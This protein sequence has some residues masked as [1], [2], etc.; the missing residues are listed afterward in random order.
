MNPFDQ[1]D[2]PP[3]AA[4][5]NPFDTFDAPKANPFDAFDAPQAITDPAAHAVQNLHDPQAREA[6]WK[7]FQQQA[8]QPVTAGSVASATGSFLKGA[9]PL[10]DD[11]GNWHWPLGSA[12]YGFGKGIASTVGQEAGTALEGAKQIGQAAGAMGLGGSF[13]DSIANVPD[14]PEGER[15][16]RQLGAGVESGALGA[17]RQI[18]T[19]GRNISAGANALTGGLIG[20]Q[21]KD[22]SDADLRKRFEEAVAYHYAQEQLT[23]GKYLHEIAGQPS[24]WN[25][26]TPTTEELAATGHPVNPE[27]VSEVA[28]TTSP[29]NMLEIGGITNP[30]ANKIIAPAVRGVGAGVEA[31]AGAT[32]KKAGQLLTSKIAKLGTPVGLAA[33]V[34]LTG[35]IHTGAIAGALGTL[36]ATWAGSK[37]AQG[38]GGIVRDAGTEMAGG[39]PT[40]GGFFAN[41]L[42][43]GIVGA[44]GSIPVAGAFALTGENAEDAGNQFWS[45]LG[46]GG[47]M[48]A[49]HGIAASPT[50][51][52]AAGFNSMADHG[53]RVNY[54]DAADTASQAITS[55]L[56]PEAASMVNYWRGHFDGATTPDGKPIRVEAV[57]GDTMRKRTGQ[58]ARGVFF[59]NGT[60][61]VKVGENEG[62]K[63]VPSDPARIAQ[64]FAHEGKHALDDALRASQPKLYHGVF[65]ALKQRFTQNGDG[66]TATP[67]FLNWIQGQMQLH[68]DNL[69]SNG[70]TDD[71][72][73]NALGK[74]DM[75]YWLN[76]ASADIGQG[77]ITGAPLGTFLLDR[78]MTGA[79][80]D[81]VKDIA[82]RAGIRTPQAGALDVPAAQRAMKLIRRQLY[83]QGSEAQQRMQVQ[84][85]PD[86]LA[87][88]MRELAPIAGTQITPTTTT[89]ERAQIRAA[90]RELAEI[91]KDLNQ[92]PAVP[93]PAAG[94]APTPPSRPN[95]PL[96]APAGGTTNAF[97][98][99]NR[100]TDVARILSGKS[101]G[102]PID[103]AKQW[104]A[105]ANGNTVDQMVADAIKQRGA[106]KFPSETPKAEPTK[107]EEPKDYTI[108]PDL[109]SPGFFH[110][111]GPD[112]NRVDDQSRTRAGA[113]QSARK[114]T[115]GNAGGFRIKPN[116]N[117]EAPDVIDAIIEQGGIHLGKLSP[118][119]RQTFIRNQF[120]RT[121]LGTENANLTPDEVARLVQSSGHGDGTISGL[122][123][124]IADAYRVRQEGKTPQGVEDAQEENYRKNNPAPNEEPTPP[125]PNPSEPIHS[126][127]NAVL[128][129]E[130]P[131]D[132]ASRPV[133]IPP[134]PGVGDFERI[135]A[136][137]HAEFLA[138]KAPAK[139]GKNKGQHT[140][141]NQKA[142][143]KAAFQAA[144]A[145][146][147]ETVPLNYEGL[148]QRT[149]AFDE[150]TIT[151]KIDPARAFDSWVIS[152]AKKSG[153][154]TDES[155]KI[156][157]ALQDAIGTTIS[158]D[159]GHAKVGPQAKGE[160][161]TA[162][163]RAASQ[164][165]NSVAKRLSGE[166]EQDT[167]RKTSMPVR[168]AFNSGND[169]FTV[170]GVSQEKLLNNFNHLTERMADLQMPM[171]FRDI[172]DPRFVAAVKAVIANHEHGW[173]GDGSAPAVGT[174]E[175]P[176]IPDPAWK[177]A[178]ERTV[179][180]KEQ[181]D[182]VNALL[183]DES[184][185]AGDSPK[186]KAKARLANA[187][188][189]DYTP[190]GEANE[191]RYRINAAT[192]PVNG[193][194]WSK[195]TLEDPL[196][197]T[198]SPALTTNIGEASQSDESIRQHGKVGDLGR[199]FPKGKTPDRAKTAAAFMPEAAGAENASEKVKERAAK[200][201]KEQG[202][203]SPFFKKWFGESKVVDGTGNPALVHHRTGA[204]DF[205]EFR[206][207]ANFG[208]K[209]QS[210]NVDLTG[211]ENGASRTYDAYLKLENPMRVRDE[212]MAPSN[213][214]QQA[215]EDGV[216]SQKEI[217]GYPY[218]EGD[219]LERRYVIDVLGKH[220]FDGIVYSNE[221]E[222]N[223]DSYIAF[224]PDQIKSATDN[225]G[226]FDPNSPD[227][228]F[229]PDDSRPTPEEETPEDT[230]AP[231]GSPQDRLRSGETS[232]QPL[233]TQEKAK[234]R[235]AA[236]DTGEIPVERFGIKPPILDRAERTKLM[237]QV[238]QATHARDFVTE[239][240][241]ID[242]LTALQAEVTAS[243]IK[244][245]QKDDIDLTK[246]DEDSNIT[247]VERDGRRYIAD[248]HNRV[249]TALDRGD[250]EALADVI[251]FMPE[252]DKPHTESTRSED[253]ASEAESAGIVLKIEDLKGLIARDP[254]VMDNVRAKIKARTGREAQFMPEYYAI[255][256]RPNDEGP[257]AF[258]LLEND[259]APREIYQHP[260]WYTGQPN[261]LAHRQTVAALE[262]IKGKPDAEVTV[263][264][265]A[266]KNSL[267]DGDWVS[268][269]RVYAKQ[270]G[271]ADD[272]SSDV[273]VHAHKVKAKDLRWPGDELGEFGYFPSRADTKFMPEAQQN[274]KQAAQ[275]RQ[276]QRQ[277]PSGRIPSA[278]QR[279]DDRKTQEAARRRIRTT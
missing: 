56:S 169:S 134:S 69:R 29:M 211:R 278:G 13:T 250:T 244:R 222:G 231:S 100:R 142:A 276:D 255:E 198:I 275:Q 38:L 141:E 199:F 204:E 190:E 223:G 3:T 257:R 179:L 57:D 33:D 177:D 85:A 209:E 76:E 158:Y 150:K 140:K 20:T 271:M 103:E 84:T 170:Y 139:A 185:K 14:S 233:T 101:I 17:G 78:G 60:L 273:P 74:L 174:E 24:A 55:Q 11:Q 125:E 42:K 261:T 173:K 106:K 227:I 98:T 216:V 136:A 2:A 132:P 1:F 212:G 26:S 75:N 62:G 12:L 153:M 22:L 146:H 37:L 89:Q 242:D 164:A 240:T 128:T 215:Y 68:L 71:Q 107:P 236:S 121:Q 53:S 188:E 43:S 166:S 4:P 201:W 197:E 104:A 265:A 183:G 10:P 172:N 81:A 31:A 112:G 148:R 111:Y 156:L 77:L 126:G 34:A 97:D 110:V 246:E 175:F 70:A 195:A 36:G 160:M 5:E 226:T 254:S 63:F 228:R 206:P 239:M 102:I 176:N 207:W 49:L 267:N 225:Q 8:K 193:K 205:A 163:E 40:G 187:N 131:T 35:G 46:L 19:A 241:P 23:K 51:D 191:L 123:D 54:G 243:T 270:H 194:T 127:G 159:Y 252:G 28:G 155:L 108:K 39:I 47:Q 65:D 224:R 41:A 208:T 90:Q 182:F 269:S 171:P 18:V 221:F 80:S 145:A 79:V 64:T 151:G 196:N 86:S 21:E 189:I 213:V 99:M 147:A 220:G 45:V 66:Q 50:K 167:A 88:R 272:P 247:I 6:A 130:S 165:Q 184:M 119:E 268:L 114:L 149:D 83:R 113:L 259:L 219:E 152:R 248:G 135:A 144:A 44:A 67:D 258:D 122:S 120:L 251:R 202:T 117:P 32:A 256:H 181:F 234:T 73:N 157:L 59:D 274:P 162:A 230:R 192:D 133:P 229:M 87:T 58:D 9:V 235:R 137:A 232:A 277:Q 186:A 264:R 217:T 253:L 116:P 105:V 168:V 214:L 95:A 25:N 245:M 266:P 200:L 30:V 94:R 279:K 154:L 82:I 180:P 262:R 27:S 129:G 115:E 7:V 93:F 109:K 72:I 52:A 263:Y 16:S 210:E 143:A 15:L 203:D 237:A 260:E 48:G 91:Q 118:E 96:P 138:D 218:N 124:A 161:Q 238:R 61:L 178:P 92:Q 249:A